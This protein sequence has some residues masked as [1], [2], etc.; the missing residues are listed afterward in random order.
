MEEKRG[1]RLNDLDVF[2]RFY[3]LSNDELL[4][5]LAK[6]NDMPSINKYIQKCFE[7]I[8]K[9]DLGN[10][11]KSITIE[12]MISEEGEKI[13]FIKGI[14]TKSEIE[15]QVFK[16]GLVELGPRLHVRRPAAENEAGQIGLRD[17]RKERLGVGPP[18]LNCANSLSNCKL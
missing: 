18:L 16:K 11:P 3:F 17:K 12:G 9:L 14:T 2:P 8:S 5:I 13:T 15:V 10:E 7:N 1:K 6:A 4:E